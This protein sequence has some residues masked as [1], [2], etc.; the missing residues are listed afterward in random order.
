MMLLKLFLTFLKIGAASFGG[1]YAMISLVTEEVTANGWMSREEVM[2]FIAVAESTPGPVAVNMATFVGSSQ[3]GFPGALMATLGVILPSFLI[4][5]IIAGLVRNLIRFRGVQA[6][7]S[8][9]RPCI[10]ALILGTAVTMGLSSFLNITAVGSRAEPD[11]FGILILAILILL[12][13]L[14]KKIR[15][16]SIS[17]ILMIIISAGLGMLFYGVFGI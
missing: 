16:R 14:Y 1:G 7:L 15:G 5:L 11:I 8:G 4:I 3:A 2:D 13:V 6:F 10:I 9:V 17:P 12:G